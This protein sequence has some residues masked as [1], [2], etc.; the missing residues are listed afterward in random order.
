MSDQSI[1]MTSQAE[2][3]R[4]PEPGEPAQE[5]HRNPPHT[6][7]SQAEGEADDDEPDGRG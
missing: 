7:P 1:P 3:E 4:E 5:E 2:G 6:T